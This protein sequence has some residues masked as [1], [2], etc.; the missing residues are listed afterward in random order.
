M[1]LASFHS[2]DIKLMLLRRSWAELFLLGIAQSSQ[3]LS[4]NTIFVTI[5]NCVKSQILQEKYSSSKFKKI[6]EHI[7]M[8]RN[9]CSADLDEFEFAYL[10]IMSLFN[11]GNC[12]QEILLIDII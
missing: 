7:L 9:F 4:I 5:I 8:L 2:D 11:A 1:N 6:S 12:K 10:R 3:S